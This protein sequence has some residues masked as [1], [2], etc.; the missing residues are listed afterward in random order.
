MMGAVINEPPNGVRMGEAKRRGSLQQRVEQAQ[1]RDAALPSVMLERVN[2]PV[3]EELFIFC[4]NVYMAAA[5]LTM[6][7]ENPETKKVHIED[8][9]TVAFS[10]IPMNRGML[11]VTNELNEQGVDE[12]T[13][14]S[15]CW[16]IMHFGDVLKETGRF[17]RWIRPL[18][19]VDS[20]DVADALIRACAH[21]KMR[22]DGSGSFDMDDVSRYAEEIEARMDFGDGAGTAIAV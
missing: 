2:V 6:P 8:V 22:V 20:T 1:D 19:G 12:V 15:L 10:D 3:D 17:A 16:R 13:R 21:A 7:V 14:F 9:G 5:S 18:D 11:A 4:T